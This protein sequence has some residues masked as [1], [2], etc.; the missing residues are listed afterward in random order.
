LDAEINIF[1]IVDEQLDLFE[2]EFL[3]VRKRS[4]KNL[5]VSI[6]NR[7][8]LYGVGVTI[9]SSFKLDYGLN[10][11][12]KPLNNVKHVMRDNS[13]LSL[14]SLMAYINSFKGY[15]KDQ[16][17]VV[18]FAQGRTGSTLLENLL[19]STGYFRRNG[20]LLGVKKREIMFPYRFISG[21]S[22]WKSKGNFIFHVKI[23]QLSRDRKRPID[24]R[25][26]FENLSKDDYAIVFLSRRNIVEHCLSNLVAKKRGL[27][28][29]FSKERE[30]IKLDINCEAFVQQVK[31]RREFALKEEEILAG[32][33]YL[34]IVYE[35]DL[36]TESNHQSTVD[37]VLDCLGLER[38][39][40]RSNMHKINTY[41]MK[42]LIANY[43]EFKESMNENNLGNFIS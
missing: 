1:K 4:C 11:G 21:L 22:K 3:E 36:L 15:N 35:D 30:H 17:R 14:R 24:V 8:F 20:E 2:N 39:P 43:D 13:R 41:E 31:E 12:R 37:R 28:H 29:K 10:I 33:N 32:L 23:Y 6:D 25:N 7:Y 38:K 40:A 16:K 26:F 9:L 34:K 5:R 42:E 19:C 27:Y 18:L